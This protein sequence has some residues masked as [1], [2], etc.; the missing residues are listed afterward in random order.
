MGK[1]AAPPA[2]PTVAEAQAAAAEG[3]LVGRACQG[4]GHSSFTDPLVCRQCGGSQFASFTSSGQGEVVSFTI[5]GVPAEPFAG[6]EPYAFVVARMAEGAMA[7]GWVEGAGDPRKLL[8]GTK[9]RVVPS[10]AG[11]GLAFEIA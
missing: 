10:P 7:S 9:V 8:P 2:L 5:I 11:R 1:G 4:C 3:T 6:R